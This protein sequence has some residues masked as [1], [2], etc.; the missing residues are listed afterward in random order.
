MIV[1]LLLIPIFG[2]V[3]GFISLLPVAYTLPNWVLSCVDLIATAL[4][5]F[6]PDVWIVCFTNIMGWNLALG[7]WA[8]L[9]FLIKKI[10]G[11]S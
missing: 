10:P 8:G 4:F 1:E 2:L 7:G 3:K 5:F 6:P 11:I 9:E